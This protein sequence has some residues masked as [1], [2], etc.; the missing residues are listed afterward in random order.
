MALMTPAVLLAATACAVR[1]GRSSPE[2][3]AGDDA[4]VPRIGVEEAHAA[5][6]AGQAVLIDVRSPESFER[7]HA[8]GAILLPL[9]QIEQAPQNAARALPAGKQPIFY[10]T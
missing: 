3:T 1:L 2:T 6:L 9:D 4:D 7:S 8:T 5:L 10:C